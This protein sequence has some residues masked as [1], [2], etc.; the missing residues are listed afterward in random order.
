MID[1]TKKSIVHKIAGIILLSFLSFSLVSN[2]QTNPYEATHLMPA[3]SE[4]FEGRAVDTQKFRPAYITSTQEASEFKFENYLH[5]DRFWSA[6]LSKNAQV[7]SVYVHVVRFEVVSGITAAHVQL[8]M[9]MAEGSEITLIS[10]DETIKRK[11]IIVSFEAGRPE[12]EG[13]N[14]FKGLKNNYVL[15]GRVASD[16][17]R[18]SEYD[19]NNK[20]EQYALS[21]SA[22]EKKKLLF[23]ALQRSHDGGLNKFYN[24]LKP[25]CTTEV[26]TLID[27]LPSLKDSGLA[28]FLTVLSND[29][30]A[31]PTIEALDQRGVLE[32][33]H[34]NLRAELERG[35]TLPPKES[36]LKP[37]AE[38]L[39]TIE[40]FPYSIVMMSPEELK[41]SAELAAAKK[42]AY[43]LAPKF[44][45]TFVSNLMVDEAGKSD[46]LLKAFKELGGHMK[47]GLKEIDGQLGDTDS[48]FSLYLTPW[49]ADLGQEVDVMKEL[50]VDVRLPLKTF[51][52]DQNN[53]NQNEVF[54]GL[55]DA[56][57]VH[58][59]NSTAFGV[60]GV[61]VQVNLV[62]GA[63]SMSMQAVGHLGDMKKEMLVE[64]DQVNI[65]EVVVPDHQNILD[66]PVAILDLTQNLN[67]DVPKF[68]LSFG[69]FGGIENTDFSSIGKFKIKS[70]HGGDKAR[71]FSVPSLRGTAA[72]V[73]FVNVW[74]DIF[75]VG[76]DLLTLS[77][78]KI[79]VRISSGFAGIKT[80]LFKDVASDPKV[81]AQFVDAVNSQIKQGVGKSLG[82]SLFEKVFSNNPEGLIAGFSK[83]PKVSK[84][85]AG[86]CKA[87]LR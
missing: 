64:N 4:D 50:D 46:A 33:R 11:D 62:K 25:N 40:G 55:N 66:Q 79:D 3:G 81:N 41:G 39:P 56:M 15:V 24:T 14:F 77:V 65:K 7:E 36:I 80:A 47:E 72:K 85:G 52:A 31:G 63:L 5:D 59:E 13:Y 82:L 76:F 87:F 68:K 32:G 48:S 57:A 26:F 83:T 49:S 30:V 17:Q 74:M 53:V 10:G 1:E 84:A 61:V 34:A 2:A 27:A 67:D 12:G 44:M 45:Q 18:L 29:P 54:T 75:S 35:E 16:I 43:T 51:E 58:A 73:G 22:D 42:T 86:S 6:E 71:A 38:L 23:D 9:K 21:L 8:R 60:M 69:A 70:P 19:K 20:T 78:N 37:K 28:P